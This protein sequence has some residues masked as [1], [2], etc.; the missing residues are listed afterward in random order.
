MEESRD[1]SAW[2]GIVIKGCGMGNLGGGQK[3]EAA[4]EW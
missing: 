2:L 3:D 1:L 4:E